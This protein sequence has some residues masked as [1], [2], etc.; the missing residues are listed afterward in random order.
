MSLKISFVLSD[1]DLNYFREALQHSRHAV[2]DAEEAEILD[3]IR[4]VLDE[5]RSNEPLPDQYPIH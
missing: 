4:V 1:R 3:A 5:I 2:R